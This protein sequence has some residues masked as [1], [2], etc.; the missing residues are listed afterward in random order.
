MKDSKN[1]HI[2]TLCDADE[3]FFPDRLKTI[4]SR[5]GETPG[6]ATDI[7]R[8]LDDKEIDAISCAIPNFWHALATIWACQAGKHVYVEKPA[9]H[10]IFEGRKMVEASRKYNVRVQVGLQNRSI[11]G[12]MEAI[13]FMRKCMMIPLRFNQEEFMIDIDFKVKDSWAEGEEVEINWRSEE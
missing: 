6:T 1:I 7:R 10:N 12:V 9:T 11:P 4:L 13:K 2:K 3:Q 8:V 5:T